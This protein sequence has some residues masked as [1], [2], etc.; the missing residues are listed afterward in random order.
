MKAQTK[1]T[2]LTFSAAE[3]AERAIQRRVV[4]AVIWGMPVV[5][6]DLMYQAMVREARGAF[7]WSNEPPERDLVTYDFKRERAI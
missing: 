6:Y 1:K 2:E 7:S 5:N 4:E 3:L